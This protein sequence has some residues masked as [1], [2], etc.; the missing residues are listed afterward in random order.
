MCNS[1][2]EATMHM[3]VLWMGPKRIGFL[4]LVTLG[5][6]ARLPWIVIVIVIGIALQ[7][8]L[9]TDTQESSTTRKREGNGR[10]AY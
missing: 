4:A 6:D 1:Q 3:W 2:R 8:T 9:S 10:N 5:N 7:T